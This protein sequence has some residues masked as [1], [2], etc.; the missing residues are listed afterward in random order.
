MQVG[1][2][3]LFSIFFFFVTEVLCFG[4]NDYLHYVV[5]EDLFV[6]VFFGAS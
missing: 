1:G 5:Y 4:A 2:P 6:C 3:C